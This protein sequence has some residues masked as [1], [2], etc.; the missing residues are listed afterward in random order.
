MK[1]AGW[2]SALV[3]YLKDAEKLE[4]VWG[5]HDCALWVAMY[6]DHLTGSRHAEEWLGRYGT[7]NECKELLRE[8]GYGSHAEIFA[9]HLT[10]RAT[11]RHARRGDVMLHPQGAVGI[12]EGRRSF[13]LMMSGLT[14]FPTTEC[15]RA[16][17]V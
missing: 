3:Q 7:E 9:L 6:V 16:W 5:Q 13:F 2:E 4:F 15:L 11:V 14:S 8:R 12:C 17:E 1:R 10:E